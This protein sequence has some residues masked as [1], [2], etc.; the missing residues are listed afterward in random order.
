MN[1]D[2]IYQEFR[3]L[4]RRTQKS[5]S[6]KNTS[7]TGKRRVEE[8]LMET[9]GTESKLFEQSTKQSAELFD[10]RTTSARSFT[11]TPDSRIKDL[12]VMLII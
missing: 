1:D 4:R 12:A 10:T 2:F 11:W 5:C 8:S 6:R 9:N 3:T 7:T